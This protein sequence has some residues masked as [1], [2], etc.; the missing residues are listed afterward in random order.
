VFE[1]FP[2]VYRSAE[3]S[4]YLVLARL[5]RGKDIAAEAIVKD[6]EALKKDG[7]VLEQRDRDEFEAVLPEPDPAFLRECDLWIARAKLLELSRQPEDANDMYDD[8]RRMCPDAA[9]AFDGLV[10]TDVELQRCDEA[11]V[12]MLAA[13]RHHQ[14]FE[15]AY[16]ADVARCRPRE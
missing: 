14:G 1:A 7:E 10:R 6:L 16:G 2:E 11:V 3:L 15:Q 4:D 9:H 13:A 8:A 12:H 5:E